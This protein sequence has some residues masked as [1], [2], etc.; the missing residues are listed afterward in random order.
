MESLFL[1]LGAW[2]LVKQGPKE[3]SYHSG[4]LKL[5]GLGRILG[6]TGTLSRSSLRSLFV[7]PYIYMAGHLNALMVNCILVSWLHSCS[8]LLYLLP[9]S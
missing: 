5:L 9:D 4:A 3:V 8:Q 1:S 2:S 6:N 7:E